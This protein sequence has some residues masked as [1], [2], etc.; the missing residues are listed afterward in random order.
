MRLL[1]A[2]LLLLMLS[3]ANATVISHNGYSWDDT[4]DIV[5]GGGLEWLRWDVTEGQS[6]N[7][8]L[9]NFS[10]AGWTLAQ[11]TEVKTLFDAFFPANT[12][13][14]AWDAD[15][16]TFQQIL[17]DWN[18][19]EGSTDFSKF[20]A[21]FGDTYHAFLD[22]TNSS[23]IGTPQDPYI[24][25]SAVFG[26]D[27]DNDNKVN[28]ALAQD[29]YSTLSDTSEHKAII[30]TDTYSNNL[31]LNGSGVVLVRVASV[32]EPTT[33]ALLS[34]GLFGLGFNKRKRI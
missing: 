27:S 1:I 22:R 29:D 4:T 26:E 2:S 20:V 7:T 8:A 34:L 33:L 28:L 25:S 23:N 9:A 21:V 3:Q 31:V 12:Y 16:F 13:G 24:N 5:T 19:S 11:N 18:S 30:T 32:P 10:G 14:T 6:I 15:E 17:V